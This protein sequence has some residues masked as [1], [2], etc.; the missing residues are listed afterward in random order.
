MTS[1]TTNA[2]TAPFTGDVSILKPP[3]GP[4]IISIQ[5]ASVQRKFVIL[6]PNLNPDVYDL[7]STYMSYTEKTGANDKSPRIWKGASGFLQVGPCAEGGMALRTV[8]DSVTLVGD[9]VLFQ[10]LPGGSN[11]A[12]GDLLIGVGAKI[13]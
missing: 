6:L 7:K 9:S 12:A 8:S 2:L 3:G 4:N 1:A 13:Q 5:Q 11:T 10:P